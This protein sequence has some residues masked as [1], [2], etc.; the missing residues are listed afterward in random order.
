MRRLVLCA[1]LVP[2]CT[3]GTGRPVENN[4]TTCANGRDDDS[5]GSVDCGDPDCRAFCDPGFDAGRS[6]PD[7]S[8]PACFGTPYTATEAFAPIDIVWVVDTSG[9]MENEAEA[10][11]NNLEAF[12]AAIGGVGLDWHVVMISTQAFVNVP[13]SLANDPR[14][15]LID[16]QVDSNAPLQALL[17]EFPRYQP[18]LRRRAFVHFVAVTDDESRIPWETFDAQMRTNLSRNYRFHTISSELAGPPSFMY[19]EGQPCTTSSGFPPEGAAAPGI[20][21]WELAA[22]TGGRTFSI[23][24][25]ESEWSSLFDTLTEAIAIPQRIPCEYELPMPTDGTT[26]D[27]YQV[28]V[29]FTSGAG[30]SSTFRYAAPGGALDCTNGGWYYDILP[31]EGMPTRIILCPSTCSEITGDVGG[32]VDVELGCLN[33]LI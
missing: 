8:L 32:R 16:R 2:A 28:N 25:P 7:S 23:C 18:H 22:T 12:A 27:V 5:D 11:Q 19:P 24:T 4:A 33:P 30:S 14:Y 10:V 1:L 3:A 13:P 31:S 9:S 15:L 17:D 6:S 21:Y 26:L 20:E 29:R